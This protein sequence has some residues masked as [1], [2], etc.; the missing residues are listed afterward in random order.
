MEQGPFTMNGDGTLSENP[1]R[2]NTNANV[3][4]LETPPGVGFSYDL[5]APLPYVAN[6]TTTTADSLAALAAFFAA[7]PGLATSKLW[8]SGES[9]AGIY[10]PW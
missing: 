4:F 6:D 1:G 10:I 7:F 5:G 8:L 2:W 3:L 9:Y